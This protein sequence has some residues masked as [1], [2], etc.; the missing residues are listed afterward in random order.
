MVIFFKT[1]SICILCCIVEPDNE[2]HATEL[3]G[4]K[5]KN[6]CQTTLRN[7]IFITAS[8]TAAIILAPLV[9]A[10][11]CIRRH[12]RTVNSRNSNWQHETEIF[13]T[14]NVD[15]SRRVY[16]EII[17]EES[18][19]KLKEGVDVTNKTPARSRGSYQTIN[20]A[21]VYLHAYQTINVNPS[22]SSNDV[23]NE[24]QIVEP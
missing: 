12:K 16:D 23:Q 17:E 3:D 6:N 10:A 11:L 15:A 19:F 13:P 20:D 14:N 24:L 7:T 5:P 8:V 4:Y 9:I 18:G 22:I 2:Y 21:M 1:Y